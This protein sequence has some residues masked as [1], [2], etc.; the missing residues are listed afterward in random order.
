[1]TTHAL[2]DFMLA[3]QR[4]FCC[5]VVIEN[6]LFPISFYVARFALRAK[7][8]FMHFVI[9]FLMARVAKSR[10]T[11]VFLLD[12]TSVTLHFIMFTQQRK[13]GLVMIKLG[14]FP[15]FFAMAFRA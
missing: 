12:V 4:V 8:P 6:D 13:F 1:M 3:Q 11:F 9:V 7:F 2:G 15:I 10:R 5:F 14:R